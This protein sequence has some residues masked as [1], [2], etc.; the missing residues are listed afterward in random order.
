MTDRLAELREGH[1]T[2]ISSAE[3]DDIEAGLRQEQDAVLAKFTPEADAIENVYIWANDTFPVVDSMLDDPSALAAASQKLDLVEEKL[4][5]VRKRLK[6]LAAENKQIAAAGTAPPASLRMRVSRYTKLGRDFMDVT[7]R[8][9]RVREKHKEVA[10]RVVKK[11]IMDMDP[12]VSETRVDQALEAGAPLETVLD[13][14][15]TE[16]QYQIDDLRAR[17][18]DIKKLTQNIVELHQM[19]TDMSILVEGQQE[20][21]NNI[22]YNVKE[23]KQDT[24]KAT[25]ELVEARRH[26]KSARKKK[27]IIAVIVIVGIIVIALVIIIPLGVSN[28][29]FSG[30][31]NNNNSGGQS[32]AQQS[33]APTPSNSA[34]S[35]ITLG[36]L[37]PSYSRP[38]GYK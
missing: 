18:D 33:P 30:G 17:N 21:I 31:S 37:P 6:R 25:E 12:A 5:A 14:N 28:G 19:F 13:V 24:K 11:G 22:E 32:P 36:N 16:L 35:R 38:R 4:G 26:Q 7:E 9:E 23:V 8:L 34:S 15:S 2:A 10:T 20:L 3:P 27:M 1:T 29:W